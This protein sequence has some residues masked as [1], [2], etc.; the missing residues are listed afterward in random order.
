VVVAVPP[1][2]FRRWDGDR[3][4]VDPGPWQ[5]SVAASATDVRQRLAL[6]VAGGDA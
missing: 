3:W 6:E 2:A 4:V 5:V 1:E